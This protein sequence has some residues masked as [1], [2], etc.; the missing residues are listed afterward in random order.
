MFTAV[1]FWYLL[2][3]VNS[4]SFLCGIIVFIFILSLSFSCH[5]TQRNVYKMCQERDKVS[6]VPN[7]FFWTKR[8]VR[9]K[10]YPETS[11]VR[12]WWILVTEQCI[13]F[14]VKERKWDEENKEVIEIKEKY[15]VKWTAESKK[16]LPKVALNSKTTKFAFRIIP[17]TASC[18]GLNR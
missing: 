7:Q 1:W 17:V 4:N 2:F 10:L 12:I 9:T 8:K 18:S 5:I 13:S 11:D 14:K 3:I 6:C 15:T 16:K